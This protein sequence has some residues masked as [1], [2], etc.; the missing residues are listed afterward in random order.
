M[1]LNTERYSAGQRHLHWAVV[2]L[3]A[4]QYF[5]FDRMGGAFRQVMETGSG[6]YGVTQIAHI[7]IGILVLLMALVR[8]LLRRR[9][10]A[11]AAPEAEPK[12]FVLLAKLAHGAL[13]LLLLALP[14]TGLI[15]WFGAMGSVAE[16]HEILT[17]ALQFLVVLHIAAVLVHQ[18]VWKTNLIRR[19]T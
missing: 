5:V 10:G 17:T 9:D 15:A 6:S 18:F 14:L 7:A 2:V 3:L 4:L 13:Y 8:L 12:P 19:M 1:T 16:V 11:P